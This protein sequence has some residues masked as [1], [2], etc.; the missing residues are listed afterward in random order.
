MDPSSA[1]PA[2]SGGGPLDG[3][4]PGPGPLRVSTVWSDEADFLLGPQRSASC[5]RARGTK[6]RGFPLD[7]NGLVP[8]APLSGDWQ[9]LAERKPRQRLQGRAAATA[10]ASISAR[11]RKRRRAEAGEDRHHT[12]HLPSCAAPGVRSLVLCCRRHWVPGAPVQ[13]GQ[14]RDSQP[15]SQRNPPRPLQM[16]ACRPF[17]RARRPCRRTWR[18]RKSSRQFSRLL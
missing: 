17:R 9:E 10:E 8:V 5:Q 4:C 18:L 11:P 7:E 12:P 3:G 13:K 6:P 16:R 1:E 14:G 15:K 2:K